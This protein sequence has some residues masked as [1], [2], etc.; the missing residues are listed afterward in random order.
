[1]IL[2][3]NKY[4]IRKDEQEL[5]PY[6]ASKIITKLQRA[7]MPFDV[8]VFD[9]DSSLWVALSRHEVLGPAVTEAL[10][11]TN[12]IR[13]NPDSIFGHWHI[14][15]GHTRFG[16]FS[17]LQMI[18]FLQQK[19]LGYE[20]LVYHRLGQTWLKVAA[21]NTFKDSNVKALFNFPLLRPM[22][23][24]RQNTRVNYNNKVLVYDENAFYNGIA[25]SLSAQGVGIEL[26]KNS[27]FKMG[28]R[29]QIHINRH[30]K[31]SAI[32]ASCRVVS[33][34]VTRNG[35]R[36]GLAFD[37]KVD[38]LREYIESLVP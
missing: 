23:K 18:Q 17:L 20:D 30:V 35:E 3:D 25:W 36:L 4:S 22:F 12:E 8:Q 32:Q 31:H 38:A 11:D 33:R 28:S 1:M 24:L 9:V 15:D 21:T 26:E 37:H 16:P 7:E 6:S 27:P 19:R 29:I 14:A 10:R 34:H 13:K 5:G 2:G